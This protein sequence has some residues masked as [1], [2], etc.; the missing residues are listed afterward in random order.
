MLSININYLYRNI[1]YND[2]DAMLY[3]PFLCVDCAQEFKS[4]Q[5]LEEHEA[6]IKPSQELIYWAD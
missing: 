4:R 1:G 2:I 5:E 3:A 6:S